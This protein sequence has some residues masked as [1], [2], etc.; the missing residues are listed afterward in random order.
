MSPAVSN[1]W[2][3]VNM[4]DE[5]ERLRCFQVNNIAFLSTRAKEKSCIF[6]VIGTVFFEIESVRIRRA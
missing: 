6:G 5:M 1:H 4:T 2:L 3:V